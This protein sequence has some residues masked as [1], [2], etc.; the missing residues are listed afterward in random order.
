[1]SKAT[2]AALAV[3]LGIGIY[4]FS[5]NTKNESSISDD[6]SDDDNG[7]SY[8]KLIGN[9]PMILLKEASRITGCN[10]YV[11]ME[12][13][14][15]GG[16]GKDRAAKSML[17]N[18]E[19]NDPKYKPGCNI[20]EGT[21]GSTGI[22]LA[23]MCLARGLK[24]HI[25]MPDDQSNEKRKLL[26]CLGATVT[27]V[28]NC[29]IS[30]K[31]HYVNRAKKLA[32]DM[33]GIFINQFENISN[34]NIHYKTTGPEIWKQLNGNINTFVMSSGTGGTI[35]GISHYLKKK[36]N[37]NI[38]IILADPNGSSLFSKVKHGVCYTNQQS[39]RTIKKH[40]Y[41]SIVEGVGLDRI[42][43]NFNKAI[44]DDAECIDDQE[45]LEMA[46][47][48]LQNEGLFVGSSSAMNVAA[49]IKYAKKIPKGS[50]IVTIICDTGQ[51]H[52]S[53]FWNCDY[54]GKYDLIWPKKGVQPKCIRAFTG[55]DTGGLN[56]DSVN[57]NSI[58]DDKASTKHVKEVQKH[59]KKGW[60][61]LRQIATG[62]EPEPEPEN[63]NDNEN[64]NDTKPSISSI[65]KAEE[66]RLVNIKAAVTVEEKR[67]TAIKAN[68]KIEEN[69]LY[70][71]KFEEDALKAA[72]K[73]EQEKLSTIKAN[74]RIEENKLASFKFD[75]DA[76]KAAIKV[77]ENELAV[78]KAEKAKAL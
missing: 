58:E 75:E 38:N 31:D 50:N 6:S 52:V 16:T 39:E 29:A 7:V 72:V 26:E 12:C 42:T 62:I 21:S 20:V 28:P 43:N 23:N 11:K 3:A 18:A 70:S 73:V 10:I 5:N 30:N 54:I 17:M 65:V 66:D 19:K 36:S 44:I 1:M 22:A 25:V 34:Y 59:A 51:R 46:H 35:S 9:T 4:H 63:E 61:V 48:L 76:I 60:G 57:E 55:G 13:M 68:E 78:I 64:E 37:N 53:R 45:I 24:L 49:T 33:N 56:N 77:E 40:R 8:E 27:I 69:K 71:L 15:P 41:D 67:L 74:E 47:W 32:K 2:I 14:N